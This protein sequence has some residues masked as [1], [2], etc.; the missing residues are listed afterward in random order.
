[1]K[2]RK[3]ILIM[4]AGA[5]IG[6]TGADVPRLNERLAALRPSNP[7]AYFELGEEVADG[8][9]S[10]EER[11]LARTLFGLAGA[12]DRDRF[13]RSACLALADIEE[14]AAQ[15]RRLLALADLLDD[16][17]SLRRRDGRTQ[18]K[19]IDP[20]AAFAV[21]Q[22][23]H[24]YRQGSGTRALRALE[25]AGAME[26]LNA[27]DD[28]LRGGARRFLEDCELY[29][30]GDPPALSADDVSRMLHLEAAL[31][32]GADRTW[33]DELL[34]TDGAT[35]IEVDPD[36]IA[37]SLHVDV[38]RPVYRDGRWREMTERRR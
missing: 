19:S 17:T 34:L 31:L 38:N 25:Q 14:D 28:A 11:T 10:I 22:A 6:M 26:L 33:T 1:M 24:E 5:V 23:L 16:G 20:A 30:S 36:Q 27:Y 35:L 7:L 3:T 37:E 21:A 15:K 4:L 2:R 9:T 29:R 13:G 18:R 12:L 8:A 32:A